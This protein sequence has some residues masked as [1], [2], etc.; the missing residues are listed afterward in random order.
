M[1][2]FVKFLPRDLH[3]V[4]LFRTKVGCISIAKLSRRTEA[5]NTAPHKQTG[6]WLNT[7]K[8]TTLWTAEFTENKQDCE[9]RGKPSLF[10]RGQGRHEA[11]AERGGS[12]RSQCW[13]VAERLRDIKGEDEKIFPPLNLGKFLLPS[14][15]D[16][17]SDF[18]ALSTPL[19]HSAHSAA[20]HLLCKELH[21]YKV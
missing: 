12:E 18:S 1:L 4:C 19:K 5:K 7:K 9:V 10:R 21:T 13:V 20:L 15:A 11:G 3:I 2:T 6:N 17:S 8:N 14:P 16:D